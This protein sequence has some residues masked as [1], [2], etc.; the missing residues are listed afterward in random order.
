MRTSFFWAGVQGVFPLDTAGGGFIARQ[1]RSRKVGS[2]TPAYFNP[3][4]AAEV[5]MYDVQFSRLMN[6][7][8]EDLRFAFRMLFR[9]PGISAAVVF[10]LA[11]AI[12]ANSA[13][14]T[15][16][17]A[18]VLRALPY[19]DPANLA[20]IWDRDAQGVQ[21]PASAANFAD[22]RGK[23]KSFSEIAG[24]TPASFQ[25]TGLD[26]PVQINGAEVTANFFRALGVKPLL[27][28]TFLPDEDGFENP[29]NAAHTAIISYRMWQDLMGGDP[30]VIGRSLQLDRV[31][32]SIA[33]VMPPDFTFRVLR[34]QVWVPVKL[35]KNDRDFHFLTTFGRLRTSRAVAAQEMQ[36]LGQA[37][38]AE[39][40][41]SNRGWSIVVADLQDYLVVS[42]AFRT[43]LLLLFAAVAMVLLIACANIASLLLARASTRTR[44]MAVRMA[45]GAGRARLARQ[46]WTEGVVLALAG[47]LGGLAL[48]EVLVRAAPSIIPPSLIPAGVNIGLN[49]NVLLFTLVV[50][51]LTGTVFGM[52]PALAAAGA[53]VREAL[54]DAGRG[55]TGGRAWVRF[56][57]S[58]VILEVALALL[59]FAGAA[60]TIESLRRMTSLDLGFDPHNVLT[61]RL[62]LP[63]SQYNAEQAL[64]FQ[65]ELLRRVRALNGVES[66]IV[67]S[68]LPLSRI[69]VEVPFD[70]ET[71]SPKE[72]AERPGVGYTTVSAGMVQTLGARLL[73]G[74]D[75]AETDRSSAPPV[76]IVNQAFADRYFPG[77]DPVGQR[78]I[79]NRPILG[80]NGF[81]G[82]LRVQIVGLIANM[83][84]TDFSGPPQPVLYA[85]QAQN[86]WRSTNFLAVR[87]KIDPAGLAAAVRKEIEALDKDLAVD[88][89]A[90][91]EKSFRD[92]FAQPRFQSQVMSGFGFI[93]LL[94]AVVGIYGVNSYEVAQRRR[95]IGIRM[96]LGATPRAI[97]G[98]VLKRGLLLAAAGI[99][100]GLAGTAAVAPVLRGVLIGIG[101]NDPVLLSSVTAAL[102]V[103]AAL[104]CLIPAVKA[105][106]VDP[107]VALRQD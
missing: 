33:G 56:R 96:A 80:K 55:S 36:S 30:N 66:A 47:G 46:L 105:T 21:W 10:T 64:Q 13:M 35:E 70:L 82:D 39:Y 59:L 3:Y 32:Y 18:L 83:A 20:V 81:E 92:Q 104:A 54:Q 53:D 100:F 28:R 12:G 98:E 101:A 107:A 76:A 72:Q 106:G 43:R 97:L 88:S 62:L 60:L 49:R 85:P 89:V 67:S 69:V 74:R 34:H 38:A 71:S 40:P 103:L 42:G 27:G 79:L 6:S 14:F 51:V 2:R 31:T 1:I 65:E 94:L 99:L 57:Q 77:Q 52:A 68:N 26:R 15:L 44:E 37:L 23:S 29:A 48:A 87:T 58:L 24:W 11:V 91:L 17:D 90:L 19:Q 73:R 75:F 25:A 41:K 9:A 78:L 8:V 4:R 45:L 7:I 50:S 102:T 5:S 84:L 22:W 95:E 63:P 61:V 16:V 86:L 93:S